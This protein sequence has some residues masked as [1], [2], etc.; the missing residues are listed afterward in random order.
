M[1]QA[2]D[3]QFLQQIEQFT[4]AVKDNVAGL[5]GGNHKS[6]KYGSSCEFADYRD[7]IEGDDVTK[8]DWNLYG[9]FEKRYLKLYLDERQRHTRI[10]IDTSR[11]RSFFNK[12]EMALK[13]ASTLAFR[14]V[15]DRDKVTIYALK[16]N[17]AEPIIENLVGKDSYRSSI[18]QLNKIKF[19]GESS[20]SDAIVRSTVGYG[21]GKSIII[22]DFCSDSNFTDAVDYLRNKRRDVRC[23]QILGDEEVHPQFRGKR[24]IHD[25]END[26]RFFKDNI[27]RDVINAYQKALKF[28]QDK[29]K[30]FCLSREADYIFCST[31]EPLKEVFLNKRLSR[32]VIE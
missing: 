8:I 23:I 6:I 25:S 24:I 29:I 26:D 18:N 30:N 14:S 9:K 27:S 2:I 16:G 12:D 21:D 28:V 7:Y 3:E 19:D 13:I 20:I 10:Y 5:F 31:D 15:S 1:K 22:S 17:Y 4:L 11:S 32:G